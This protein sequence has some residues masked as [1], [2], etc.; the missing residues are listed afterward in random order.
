MRLWGSALHEYLRKKNVDKFCHVAD[1]YVTSCMD[2]LKVSANSLLSTYTN[3]T[4][5]WWL[6][7]LTSSCLMTNKRQESLLAAMKQVI[8]W[9]PSRRSSHKNRD[10]MSLAAAGCLAWYYGSLKLSTNAKQMTSQTAVYSGVYKVIIFVHQSRRQLHIMQLYGK[11]H[12]ILTQPAIQYDARSTTVRQ[13]HSTDDLLSR[14]SDR[15]CRPLWTMHTLSVTETFFKSHCN[16]Y[17]N[18][19]SNFVTEQIMPQVSYVFAKVESLWSP[20]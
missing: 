7:A 13:S 17:R 11:K 6:N 15:H 16:C 3:C 1:G 19:C 8:T 18:S 2:H 10:I 4:H 5:M 12:V 14:Q 20:A 9:N